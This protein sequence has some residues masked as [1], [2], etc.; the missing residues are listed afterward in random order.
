M[1]D[2]F[3]SLAD[4][5]DRCA[6]VNVEESAGPRDEV[7]RDEK[8]VGE[9]PYGL[10]KLW[11]ARL[12]VLEEIDELEDEDENDQEINLKIVQLKSLAGLIMSVLLH[13]AITDPDL[14]LWKYENMFIGFKRGWKV[15]VYKDRR[16]KQ[17]GLKGGQERRSNSPISMPQF[18]GFS[19]IYLGR[20]PHGPIAG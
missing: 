3:P 16:V 14:K 11:L 12:G 13:E 5:V 4:I 2:L 6:M 18:S 8:V 20:G 15:V 10:R 19:F 17:E 1:E 9:M 7:A